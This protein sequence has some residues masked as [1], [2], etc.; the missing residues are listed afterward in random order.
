MGNKKMTKGSKRMVSYRPTSSLCHV[1]FFMRITYD[2]SLRIMSF[3]LQR[4]RARAA[5]KN[6]RTMKPM[7]VPSLTSA[8]S[9]V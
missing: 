3:A 2:P 5:P 1:G 6:I 9:K 4:R 7:Y 8:F